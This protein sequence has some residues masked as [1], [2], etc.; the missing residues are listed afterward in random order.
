MALFLRFDALDVFE[1]DGL[2]FERDVGAISRVL[3]RSL[4]ESLAEDLRPDPVGH[5]SLGRF[6]L[7][8]SFVHGLGC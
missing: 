5:F 6:R 4:A 1:E 7:G 3:L 8:F 2:R